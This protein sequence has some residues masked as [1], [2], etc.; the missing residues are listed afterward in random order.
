MRGRVL[1]T[2]T[3]EPLLSAR[4]RV[5]PSDSQWRQVEPDGRIALPAPVPGSYTIE[6]SAVGYDVGSRAVTVR[7]DSGTTWIA[8]MSRSRALSRD[9]ACTVDTAIVSNPERD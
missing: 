8:A 4:A 6:V 7:A 3:C 9:R 5:V 1:S 2:E